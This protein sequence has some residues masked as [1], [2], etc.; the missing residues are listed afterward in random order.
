MFEQC[1]SLGELN[2]ERQ[3][4]IRSGHSVAEVNS[5][6]NKVRK[7]L[8][9]AVPTFRKIPTYTAVVSEPPVYVA[10]PIIAGQGLPNEIVLTAA[11]VLL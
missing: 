8:M 3:S 9:E 6:Y 4:L 7:S 5:A 11:G 10:L 1:N 2:K